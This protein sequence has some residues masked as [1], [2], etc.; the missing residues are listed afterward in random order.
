MQMAKIVNNT[1]FKI[2]LLFLSNNVNNDN[3]KNKNASSCRLYDGNSLKVG[4]DR[5]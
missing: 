2:C 5:K 4:K 3:E 1:I